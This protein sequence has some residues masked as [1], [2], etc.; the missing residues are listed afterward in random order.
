MQG[1]ALVTVAAQ[2]TAEQY[3]AGLRRNGLTSTLE[4]DTGC[5]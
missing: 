4:P 3:V 5:D 1:L 2:E